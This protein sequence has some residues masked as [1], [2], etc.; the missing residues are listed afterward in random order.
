MTLLG[1]GH[2][3]SRMFAL[4]LLLAAWA[5]PVASHADNW[6]STRKAHI[7][8]LNSAL[9]SH[10]PEQ[11][12]NR[13]LDVLMRLY[14]TPTGTGLTWDDVQAVPSSAHETMLRWS[15]PGG[16]ETIRE[17]YE[18]LLELFA[19]IHRVELRIERVDW[20][21]PGPLGYRTTVHLIVRGT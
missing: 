17:R 16:K 14:A 1:Q 9:H 12:Q 21:N 6:E 10:W 11:L 13:D 18:K 3:S 7:D 19:D 4:I 5:T 15:G 2:S 8:P 20:R